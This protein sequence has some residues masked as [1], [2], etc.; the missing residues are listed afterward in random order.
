MDRKKRR[1]SPYPTKFR[2]RAIQKVVDHFDSYTPLSAAEETRMASETACRPSR[3]KLSRTP[4]HRVSE[5]R[6]RACRSADGRKRV[7]REI[8][9]GWGGTVPPKSYLPDGKR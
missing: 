4:R 5:P 6:R 1:T 7:T 3:S 2:E 8:V 9:K